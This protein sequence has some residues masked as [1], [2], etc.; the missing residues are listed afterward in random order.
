[1]QNEGASEGGSP[2]KQVDGVLDIGI[3]SMVPICW[4]PIMLAS[5]A[6]SGEKDLGLGV[7]AMSCVLASIGVALFDAVM[8]VGLLVETTPG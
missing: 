5:L 6:P 4:I 8:R 3:W 1:M 2:M 7:L